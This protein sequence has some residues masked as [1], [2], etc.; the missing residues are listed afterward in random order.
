MT[1]HCPATTDADRCPCG[2]ELA[3]P[4]ARAHHVCD[5]CRKDAK[6]A[7]RRKAAKPDPTVPLFDQPDPQ[8]R[9]L[10]PLDG[11]PDYRNEGMA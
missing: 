6:R 3:S 4:A 9:C 5:Y 8:P 1:R 7:A 11:W 10:V 2:A